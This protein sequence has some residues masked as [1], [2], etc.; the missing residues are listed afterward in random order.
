MQTLSDKKIRRTESEIKIEM[1][2]V[3]AYQD[4]VQRKRNVRQTPII[5]VQIKKEKE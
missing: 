5:F 3:H 2:R 4:K 1:M